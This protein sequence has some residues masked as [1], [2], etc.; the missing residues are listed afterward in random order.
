MS[1]TLGR[2]CLALTLALL[3]AGAA[4]GQSGRV[5]W[6]G[7]WAGGWDKGNGVQLVFAGETLIAFNW[8]GDYKDVVRSAA[9]PDGSRSFA[10]DKGE[11]TATRAGNAA[12]LA[13][14][15][16]GKPAVSVMLKRE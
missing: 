5:G 16:Q 11:A 9:A 13:V 7:T 15:E 10:W 3:V 14:R 4:L 1:R 2:L 6:D 12:S 8:R